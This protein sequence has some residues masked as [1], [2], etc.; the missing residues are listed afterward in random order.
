MV[1]RSQALFNWP[2]LG[3]SPI[4]TYLQSCI[5]TDTLGQA[6]LLLG[7]QHIGKYRIALTA[8]KSILCTQSQKKPCGICPNCEQIE[9]NIHADVDIISCNFDKKNISIQQIRHLQHKLSLR[10]FLA[11]YKI[12]IINGAENL[13][14]EAANAL[15][16][17]LEEPLGK[18]VFFL[19]A[20]N[21]NLIPPTIVSRCLQLQCSVLPTHQIENWLITRGTPTTDA[22]VLAKLANGKPG[23]AINA[24]SDTSFVQQRTERINILLTVLKSS[25]IGRFEAVSK[26]VG[27]KEETGINQIDETLKDW[28]SLLR[29]VYLVRSGISQ[30]VNSSQNN[31]IKKLAAMFTNSRLVR[32][33]DIISKSRSL[34][35]KSVNPTIILEHLVLTI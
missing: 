25:I 5:A 34:L 22:R 14:E 26:L 2:I 3:H 4:K 15:L 13:S 27:Q 7:P 28:L 23:I 17:T 18:T 30:V 16:K 21:K 19:I 8:A 10:S 35:A 1:T 11:S 31:T 20:E 24:L 29:D 32:S 9:K 12:A 6:Y 33:I